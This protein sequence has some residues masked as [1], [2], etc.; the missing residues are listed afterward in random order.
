M[1]SDE[2]YDL[3][4]GGDHNTHQQAL[5]QNLIFARGK[6]QMFM[7]LTS[8]QSRGNSHRASSIRPEPSRRRSHALLDRSCTPA[9]A[10]EQYRK[11]DE[12]LK[13]IKKRKVRRFYE[14][15]VSTPDRTLKLIIELPYR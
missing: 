5:L 9:Q 7:P 14:N 12:E 2:D 8:P 4:P 13:A 1:A 10:W 15:Q 3:T 6:T 11:S